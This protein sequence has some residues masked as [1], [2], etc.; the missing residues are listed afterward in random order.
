MCVLT[1]TLTIAVVIH[2]VVKIVFYASHVPVERC[3]VEFFRYRC[4]DFQNACYSNIEMTE[5]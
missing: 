2:N 1:K 4:A 5:K 3:A